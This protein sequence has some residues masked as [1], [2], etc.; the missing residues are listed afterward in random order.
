MAAE[1]ISAA[2]TGISS[3]LFPL[4]ILS[5]G[6]REDFLGLLAS[7]GSGIA[8]L[9]SIPASLVIARIGYRRSIL[10]G[11]IT[12]VATSF[13]Q[14]L[15]P[16]SACLIV[17]QVIS[18]CFGS[19]LLVVHTPYLVENVG[20]GYGTRALSLSMAGVTIVGMIFNAVGG[21]LPARLSALTGL[22]QPDSFGAYR[23]GLLI[24]CIVSSLALLPVV[25]LGDDSRGRPVSR[26]RTM[27]QT[28][29]LL[30]SLAKVAAVSLSLGFGA[31]LF[32]PFMNLYWKTRFSAST[33]A[34]GIISAATA[35]AIGLGA[36]AA[37]IAERALGLKK[38]IPLL[39]G[40]SLI[41]MWAMTDCSRLRSAVCLFL[42]RTALVNATTPLRMGL[43]MKVVES[44][45]RPLAAS[46]ESLTWSLAWAGGAA[47][48]GRMIL[49]SGY[50]E[51]F[52]MSL[53]V[54][55]VAT[56]MYAVCFVVFHHG[57]WAE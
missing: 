21:W 30:A 12:G 16:T 22:F 1:L 33:E 31:G 53:W 39:T 18:A 40:A 51:V 44:E 8:G 14:V 37:P 34:I 54:Y 7:L 42:L 5:A 47:C 10:M 9:M 43:T 29:Y 13:A 48:G 32:M 19:M 27:P 24:A 15:W 26:R 28:F 11:M 4:F 45:H 25:F 20:E 6:F 41:P 23:A 57:G 50:A 2:G 38:A 35:A 55:A 49:A 3:V 52:R 36:I 46:V 56:A 17:T